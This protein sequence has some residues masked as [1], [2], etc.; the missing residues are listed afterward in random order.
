MQDREEADRLWP[1]HLVTMESLRRPLIGLLRE[2]DG[3]RFRDTLLCGLVVGLEERRRVASLFMS[4]EGEIA[5]RAVM[6]LQL[7]AVETGRA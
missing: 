4:T 3:F 7:L 1:R 5:G 6:P 2:I